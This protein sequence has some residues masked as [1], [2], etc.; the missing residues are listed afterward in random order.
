M[1]VRDIGEHH[2]NTL[3]Q[4]GLNH[5]QSLRR[6]RIEVELTETGNGVSVV[7]GQAAQR[8]RNVLHAEQRL[9]AAVA[10]WFVRQ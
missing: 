9:I 6:L 3:L 4:H 2:R 1:C 10:A 5:R 7:V 8:R